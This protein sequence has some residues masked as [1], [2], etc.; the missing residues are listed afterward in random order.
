MINILT[1]AV[2]RVEF[3]NDYSAN[4]PEWTPCREPGGEIKLYSLE[5]AESAMAEWKSFNPHKL[6]YR[7]NT[8]DDAIENY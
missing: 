5:D 7:V 6:M 8:D 3:A 2:W 1:A 4:E